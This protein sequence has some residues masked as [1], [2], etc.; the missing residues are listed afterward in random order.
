MED[1]GFAYGGTAAQFISEWHVILW[2]HFPGCRVHG[3][4]LAPV[5]TDFTI[6]GARWWPEK[7]ADG[8]TAE[9]LKLVDECLLLVDLLM[10]TWWVLENPVGRLATLR[11]SLGAPRLYF[12]P[13]HYAGHADVPDTDAYTKKTGLWG[14]FN[15]NLE[16]APIEPRM[17]TLANGKRGS[18]MWAKLGGKSARTK[19]LR[20][21]T[22]QGFA[23]A[24]AKANP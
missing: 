2:K 7:D 8:R 13:C 22:P 16:R 5:C 14:N 17:V 20:S 1:G 21:V 4:M 3:L 15:E 12:Q 24:F 6:S 9:S 23:R 11:P 10:P 18:W 19:E